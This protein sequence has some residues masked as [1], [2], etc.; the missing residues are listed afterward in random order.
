[1]IPYQRFWDDAS[2][3]IRAWEVRG[4]LIIEGRRL[5]A[6][7]P[8]PRAEFSGGR[9][10]SGCLPITLDFPTSLGWEISGISF[11]ACRK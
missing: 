3:Q 11:S 2:A 8:A 6:P 7:A 1:M 4:K 10:D 5:D 9:G